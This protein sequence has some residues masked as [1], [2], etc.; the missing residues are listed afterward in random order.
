MT[1]VANVAVL[2]AVLC[3]GG[4]PGS[5]SPFSAGR[6]AAAKS[7]SGA[8][9]ATLAPV[10]LPLADDDIDCSSKAD[11]FYPDPTDACS[12]LF[13]ACSGGHSHEM[14]CA[15]PTVFDVESGQCMQREFVAA[16]G[17]EATTTTEAPLRMSEAPRESRPPCFNPRLQ[18]SSSTAPA[19]PT[20]TTRPTRARRRT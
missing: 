7:Y 13:Y 16:C 18:R 8:K 14:E 3:A 20:A 5:R 1:R 15:E 2:L 9:V 12:D 10:E 4:W 11:G 6:L 19:G 17:G